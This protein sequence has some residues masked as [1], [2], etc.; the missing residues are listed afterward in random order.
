MNM[1]KRLAAVEAM[2]LYWIG[3]SNVRSDF[4]RELM[5]QS[6]SDAA[7]DAVTREYQQAA[8]YEARAKEC[9]P[10]GHCNPDGSWST[11][12]PMARASDL[13]PKDGE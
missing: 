10:S 5:R 1:D 11:W 7:S 6:A 3:R 8:A 2:P 9:R 13:R 12:I 4:A